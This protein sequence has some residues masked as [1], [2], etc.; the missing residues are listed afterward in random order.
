MAEKAKSSR[1]IFEVDSLKNAYETAPPEKKPIIR[2]ALKN[3]LENFIVADLDSKVDRWLEPSS[4]GIIDVTNTNFTPM[5]W[6]SLMCYV[7]GFFYSII[8]SCGIT[9]ERLCMDLLLSHKLASDERTLSHESLDPLLAIP[10]AH[11]I[12]LLYDWGIINDDNRKKLHRIN[13]IR[14]KYVHP[15]VIPNLGSAE[16]ISELQKDSL[17]ILM[18]L[19]NILSKSFPY[20]GTR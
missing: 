20:S 15:D 11:M 2:E 7:H 5:F 6:E 16:G 17:E 9:A 10:H 1:R 12:E 3:A 14:N 8:S 19:K 18:I 4:M 13:E